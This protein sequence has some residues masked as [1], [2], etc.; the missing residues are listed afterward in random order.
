MGHSMRAC[1]PTGQR[2]RMRSLPSEV[3]ADTT[4]FR[5]IMGGR[6]LPEGRPPQDRTGEP[7]RTFCEPW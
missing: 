7:H 2:L 6:H 4:E 1:S 5:S 3:P